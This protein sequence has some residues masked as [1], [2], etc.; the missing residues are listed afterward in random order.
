MI[1]DINTHLPTQI[2]YLLT[3]LL[4]GK[5]EI[6]HLA[7]D[8]IRNIIDDN[9]FKTQLD[10]IE[11][12]Y[13]QEMEMQKKNTLKHIQTTQELKTLDD[14]IQHINQCNINCSRLYNDYIM[15]TKNYIL[16]YI[17]K[18]EIIDTEEETEAED[19]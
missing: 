1:Y 9:N 19:G 2:E 12:K 8:N 14:M 5:P 15:K 7:L 16:D 10:N 6:Y 13:N 3:S 11:K 18:T 17:K 4:E